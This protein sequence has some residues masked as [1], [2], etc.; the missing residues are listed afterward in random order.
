[1][2]FRTNL[3]SLDSGLSVATL[4]PLPQTSQR[5]DEQKKEKRMG[6]TGGRFLGTL[7]H[8]HGEISVKV[9]FEMD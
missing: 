2:P 6:G 9:M 8:G 3:K 7:E 5:E 4:G 1:M